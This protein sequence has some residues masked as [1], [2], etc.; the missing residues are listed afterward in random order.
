MSKRIA[1]FGGGGWATAIAKI[2]LEKEPEINWDTIL[3]T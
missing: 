3:L 2:F 1:I